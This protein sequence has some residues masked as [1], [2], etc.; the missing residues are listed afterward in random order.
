MDT[1]EAVAELG[2]AADAFPVEAA[3]A[4]DR[5]GFVVV[6]DVLAPG[7]CAAMADE[8]DRLVA[9]D[10]GPVVDPE[11]GVLRL[12]D[13]FNKSPVF[14]PLF[15][16]APAVAA[17]TA[18]LGDIRLH[19]ANLREPQRGY[20]HQ[21]LHSDVPKAHPEDWRVLNALIALDTV[22]LDNGPT[23]AVPGSHRWP[24]LG[25]SEV[26]SEPGEPPSG[27]YGEVWRFPTD[28][29][30]PYPGEVVLTLPAGAVALCNASLWHGG[31]TNVSGGRRRLAHI[32][33]T[34][35]DRKQQFSQQ[36]HLT[37]ALWERLSDAE[38]HLLDVRTPFPPAGRRA[39]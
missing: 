13:P 22:T 8:F 9:G 10:P 1:H 37:P 12:S 14:D 21:P 3:T 17:A 7:V 11:P 33:Y 24:H 6:A 20:G 4:L 5:D 19:G 32:T 27:D 25:A 23:R 2:A 39:P 18:L 16:L 36:D 31:T 34:R 38:R 30:E 35:R 28:R 29:D 26:N 15:R